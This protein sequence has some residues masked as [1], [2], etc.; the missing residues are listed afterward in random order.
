MD[1]DLGEFSR[2]DNEL[3]YQIN[4]VVAIAAEFRWW[5]LIRPELAI[6]L[7]VDVREQL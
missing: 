6:E 1:K 4:S 5:G 3:G 2:G 7:D